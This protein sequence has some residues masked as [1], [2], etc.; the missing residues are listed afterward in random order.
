[1]LLVVLS[2][3][4]TYLKIS[5]GAKENLSKIN[6]HEWNC[7]L[8]PQCGQRV[9]LGLIY[10]SIT[11]RLT[12]YSRWS[13]FLGEHRQLFLRRETKGILFFVSL[14]I[15]LKWLILPQ[16]QAASRV[17]LEGLGGG[18]KINLSRGL[19]FHQIHKGWYV[20]L[21][22][23]VC[24][25]PSIVTSFSTDIEPSFSWSDTFITRFEEQ[26]YFSCVRLR[27]EQEISYY[28]S[29]ISFFGLLKAV[30]FKKIVE[31]ISKSKHVF[32]CV[33]IKKPERS[34]GRSQ[35]QN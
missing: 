6:Y 1:M 26:Y 18:P 33:G 24:Q 5:A 21:P 34:C 31:L 12:R 7:L 25:V 13:S 35:G 16:L 30:D 3:R 32:V 28:Y 19:F 11:A 29:V 20:I 10:Y 15:H 23:W 8:S 17:L 22:F 14:L 27:K 2:W 9:K 4:K